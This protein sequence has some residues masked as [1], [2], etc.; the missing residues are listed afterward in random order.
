M[1]PELDSTRVQT[2]RADRDPAPPSAEQPPG[3]SSGGEQR[4]R[5][6]SILREGESLRRS[7]ADAAAE[8]HRRLNQS[9]E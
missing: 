3:S 7:E 1:E 2:R 5:W 9:G 4:E 6:R 8:L